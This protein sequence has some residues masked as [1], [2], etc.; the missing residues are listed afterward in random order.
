MYRVITPLVRQLTLEEVEDAER[1]E[2]AERE[3]E[4][5]RRKI[6]E[7][8]VRCSRHKLKGWMYALCPLY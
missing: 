2:E 5:T 3:K 1:E 8:R 4:R 6:N 7:D